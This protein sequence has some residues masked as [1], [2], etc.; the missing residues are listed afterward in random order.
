MTPTRWETR[1]WWI[2]AALVLAFYLATVPRVWQCEGLDEIDYLALADSLDRGLGYTVYG[3]PHVVYPPLFPALLAKATHYPE[4]M[5]WARLYRL[6]AAA[7]WAGLV[8]FCAALRRRDPAA[9]APASWLALLAY[10]PWSFSTRYL[11]AE[12]LHLLAVAAALFLAGETRGGRWRVAGI[13]VALACAVLSKAGGVALAAAFGAAGIVRWIARR[14]FRQALPFLAVAGL[15]AGL[16]I[17]WEIR[18]AIVD[19][20]ARES[21]GRWVLKWVGLSHETTGVVAGNYGEGVAGATSLS[22]RAGF[23]VARMGQYLLSIPRVPPNLFALSGLLGILVLLGVGGELRRDAGSPHPWYLIATF[24]MVAATSWVSSYLRYLYPVT[25]LLYFYA[26]RGGRQ[27]S[28]ALADARLRRWTPAALQLAGAA[29]V[30]ATVWRGVG[31][32][33]GS[34]GRY[35]LCTGVAVACVGAALLG[36]P[37][38][39]KLLAVPAVRRAALPALVAV[40]ALNAGALALQRQRLCRSGAA[41]ARRGLDHVFTCADWARQHLPADARIASSLPLLPALL[42]ARP[43]VA[44]EESGDPPTTRYVW[45]L[46]P[47]PGGPAARRDREEALQ[48]AVAGGGWKPLVRS[49]PAGIYERDGAQAGPG[50]NR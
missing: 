9:G 43:H 49:G 10:Y 19:P 28:A 20:G 46:G 22:Q 23:V 25:P 32:G 36:A 47:G 27:L 29:I 12:Q 37:L 4:P 1:A 30:A 21:Y 5:P 16:M 48:R 3:A 45:L 6:N 38:F 13:A 41:V 17:G 44:W 34:E 14:S 2:A 50:Q 42:T 18:A 39:G 40:L 15:A 11:M 8:L 33:A 26:V 31:G 24:A 7:G 35:A